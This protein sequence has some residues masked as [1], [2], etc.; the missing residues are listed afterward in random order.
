VSCLGIEPRTCGLKGRKTASFEVA[1]VMFGCGFTLTETGLRK[2]PLLPIPPGPARRLN[3]DV[4]AGP[5]A[6]AASAT[7]ARDGDERGAL[8]PPDTEANPTLGGAEATVTCVHLRRSTRLGIFADGK[9]WARADVPGAQQSKRASDGGP[10]RRLL[11]KGALRRLPR[12]GEALTS[13][14]GRCH[15]PRLR[16]WYP[17]K[18]VEC[19]VQGRGD[20]G[21]R[22]SRMAHR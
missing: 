15:E 11:R 13:D 6:P 16:V 8:D 5:A 4:P 17:L 9:L 7:V 1:R 2:R 20:L 10:A 3:D 14:V 18:Q 19:Q 12:M 21:F 22:T